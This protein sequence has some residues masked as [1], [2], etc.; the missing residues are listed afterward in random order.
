MCF[1]IDSNYPKK[2]IA[3]E[4]IVCYKILVPRGSWE[5]P[6]QEATYKIGKLKRSYIG[7]TTRS[8]G[9]IN[10]GLHSYSTLEVA[11]YYKNYG[12]VVFESIIPKGAKYFYNEQKAEYVSNKLIVKKQLQ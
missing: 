2:L 3:T 8:M 12:K 5:S 4:D 9:V 10:H 6:V 11:K 7:W 1:R